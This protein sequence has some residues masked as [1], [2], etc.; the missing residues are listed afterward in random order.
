MTDVHGQRRQSYGPTSPS[1]GPRGTKTL[2]KILDASLRVFAERGFH[3]TTIQDIVDE[4]GTSRA[5]LYQYF[6]SKEQIFVELLE[7][8]GAAVVDV[9]KKLGELG[10]TSQGFG[11]LRWWLAEWSRVYDQYSTM[12]IEWAN[13]DTP[14]AHVSTLVTQFNTNFNNRVAARLEQSGVTGI[15]PNDA[16]IVLTGVILRFNYLRHVNA[17]SSDNADESAYHFAVLIQLMLF[18]DTPPLATRGGRDVPRRW[19]Q[20]RITGKYVPRHPEALTEHYA[21]RTTAL[22]ARSTNTVHALMKSG[23]RIFAEVGYQSANIDDIVADAGFARGTFYKYFDGKI[24]LLLAISHTCSQDT[25]AL[26]RRLERVSTDESGDA[27]LREWVNAAVSLSQEYRG[28]YRVWMERSPTNEALSLM[29][30]EVVETVRHSLF[31]LLGQAERGHPIDLRASEIFVVALL[32]QVPDAFHLIQKTPSRA[33]QVDLVATILERALLGGST[34]NRF[35][36]I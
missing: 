13:I 32:D 23:A 36:S 18:P 29:R 17:T 19:H 10:P 26:A 33:E 35:E 30:G 34:L 15:N 27:G 5:T 16:A 12:F 7:E 24:D 8:C 25:V 4:V 21:E 9:T 20:K 6:E 28:I 14:A 1:I 22:T 31:V 3:D 11:N 2:E